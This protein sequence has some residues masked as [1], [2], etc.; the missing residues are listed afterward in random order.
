MIIVLVVLQ[1]C[2]AAGDTRLLVNTS[3]GIVRG[4]IL[5]TR[6]DVDILAFHG[7]RY[8][9]PPIGENRFKAP[10]PVKPW[11][12]IYNATQPNVACHQP[13]PHPSYI[14]SEDCLLLDIYTKDLKGLQPVIVFIHGGGFA[15]GAKSDVRPEYL[16]ERDVVLVSINYRLHALG[17]LSTG[18]KEAPGNYGFKDQV[19][20]LKWVRDN[21]QAFG[22]DPNLVTLNGHSAGSFSVSLHLVSP[23]SKGLFHRAILM[24]GSS[25]S[26]QKSVTRENSKRIL[27]LTQCDNNNVTLAIECLRKLPV[28][29]ISKN[30][31]IPNDCVGMKLWDY[32]IEPAESN[33]SF[34]IEDPTISL[35]TGHL[36]D[37]PILAGISA[38][39]FSYL[40][41]VVKNKPGLLDSINGN[42]RS[43]APKCFNYDEFANK[44]E[45]TDAL[46]KF[47][48]NNQP[49]TDGNINKFGDMFADGMISF[50][51]YRFLSL[52]SLYK[53]VYFY[54]FDYFNRFSHFYLPDG[55]PL[56]VA[57][58]DELQYMYVFSKIAREISKDDPENVMVEKM[59]SWWA[60]FAKTGNPN[61]A[62]DE[63]IKDITWLPTMKNN[64]K[65]LYINTTCRMGCLPNFARYSL[66]DSI[67]PL[68]KWFKI[69]V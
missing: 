42:F 13:N 26:H 34:L 66:W 19:L 8:A 25:M 9:E 22:G 5:R 49:V 21:I 27:E 10:K 59:T 47:Y 2:A 69:N 45:V 48:L 11:K 41:Y 14:L 58:G 68:P 55:L 15:M 64:L 50:G 38:D 60:Q 62:K 24:S 61:N 37:I 28:E 65:T 12:G 20:A 23:M 31:I 56:G 4:S 57:H 18:S 16:L 43:Y 67:F 3:N 53:D 1:V 51:V 7:V 36:M 40:A 63:H 33:D 29:E 46:R 54:E 52:V 35:L 44:D 39:E 6:E 32:D 30:A 17:F